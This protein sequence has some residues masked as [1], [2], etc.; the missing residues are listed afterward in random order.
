[1]DNALSY[2][3]QF[4]LTRSQI[5]FFVR[6]ALDE[7]DA[8]THNPLVVH[9]CLKVLDEISKRVKEGI[10]EAVI[11]EASKY[12]KSF[13]FMGARIQLTERRTYDYS[14]DDTWTQ[15]NRSLKQREEL[16]K[17]LTTPMANAET[18]EVIHPIPF[19]TTSIIMISLPK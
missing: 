3:T 13:D 10:S 17:Y 4:N 12:G 8:G 16:L 11:C 15:I 7:V 9:L 5:D 6:K 18:A 1:M 14:K 19:K 2:I